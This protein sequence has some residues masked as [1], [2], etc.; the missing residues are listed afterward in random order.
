L[1]ILD[2]RGNV[3]TRVAA[4]DEGRFEAAVLAVAGLSRLGLAARI[5]DVLDPDVMLPAAGQGALAIETREDDARVRAACAAIERASTRSEVS[6]ERSCLRHLGAGCQAPVGALAEVEIGKIRL[7]AAVALAGRIES[8]DLVGAVDEA[9]AVGAS[10][11]ERLL[12]RLG[13]PT[14]RGIVWTPEAP[15]EVSAP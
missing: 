6:A 4:V 1:E 11:A 12:E 5:S 8:V 3:P 13:L 10:A 2:M 15:E 7:R 14:L 9:D